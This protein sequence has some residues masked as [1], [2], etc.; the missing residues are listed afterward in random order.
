MIKLSIIIP[1]FKVESYIQRCLQSVMNQTW[2]E[3]GIE[4]ECILIDDC[5]PDKSM[6]LAQ[7]QIADYQGDI[8]FI[9]LQHEKNR[10]LS[11]ARNTGM[12]AA[13]GDY[14][15]FMDSDDYMKPGAIA[16]FTSAIMG[17][18]DVDVFLGQVEKIQDHSI[19]LAKILKPTVIAERSKILRGMLTGRIHV[20]AWNKF[21]RRSLLTDHQINFIEGIYFEDVTWSYPLYNHAQKVM[22]I[23]QITY[24]YN[25][26]P[27]GIMA[28]SVK[29]ERLEK[30][31]TSLAVMLEYLLDHEPDR[32]TFGQNIIV[33]Y[34]LYVHNQLTRSLEYVQMKTET[35]DQVR[36]I[37]KT[38]QR[39]MK[40]ALKSGRILLTCFMLLL[41]NPLCQLFRL[42][43]FRRNF[44]YQQKIIWKLSHLTDFL[45]RT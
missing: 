2:T 14:V 30:T 3:N 45:H 24:V 34:L 1:V 11:A 44:Y 16:A 6:L 35:N 41:Y 26:N 28:Q 39:L 25:Y 22:F 36:R 42:R 9:C 21:V 7:Q 33:E 10:G 43:S 18:P 31:L 12:Q 27:T 32:T 40:R 5:S 4:I 38:R 20:E 15:Y 37:Y 23:P 29:G 8:H 17:H 13:T 19:Y